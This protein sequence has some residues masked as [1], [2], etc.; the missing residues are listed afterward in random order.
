MSPC[1]YERTAGADVD[2]FHR[3]GEQVGPQAKTTVRAAFSTIPAMQANRRRFI[4]MGAAAA[5]C[6]PLG[7]VRAAGS[8]TVIDV[9]HHLFPPA[10]ADHLRGKMPEFML[11]GAE[12]AIG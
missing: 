10:I 8:R 6:S 3:W 7:I 1:Q 2:K 5:A 11:P 12:R 9:H 4:A